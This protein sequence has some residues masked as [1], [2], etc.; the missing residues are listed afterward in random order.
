MRSAANI[1]LFFLVLL[2]PL[3]VSADHIALPHSYATLSADGKFVFVMI[4]AIEAERDGLSLRN[5]DKQRA[6]AIR[7]KYTTS[8]MYRNDGSTTPLWTVGWYSYSVL[9]ASDG[10]HLVR[11]GP[12]ANR[13]SDE[14]FTFFN[15]GNEIRNYRIGD[16][17]D[18][19]ALLPHSVSH[20]RWEENVHLDD[21]KRV[22]SVATLSKEKYFFDFTTGELVSARR[23]LRGIAVVGGV[24]VALLAVWGVRR[25]KLTPR[26]TGT[27]LHNEA[28]TV[29]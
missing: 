17:V 28:D 19:A 8:G 3:L 1:I 23:P 26:S 5:E 13:L 10:V 7:A 15:N 4:A 12:W 27:E 18:S 2:T 24:I 11:L 21:Q 9:V 22:L 16:L 20:F 25:R 6:K 14:A 29:R